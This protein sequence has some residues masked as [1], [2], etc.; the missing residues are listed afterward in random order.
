MSRKGECPSPPS[1]K[2]SPGV[3]YLHVIM[4]MCNNSL[5]TTFKLIPLLYVSEKYF[6]ILFTLLHNLFYVTTF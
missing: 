3:V 2:R 6:T 5:L 1:L 4:C